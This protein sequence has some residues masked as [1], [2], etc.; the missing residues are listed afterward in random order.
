MLISDHAE[1]IGHSD[2]A[3]GL[4]IQN[5]AFARL[6]SY[7]SCD[8]GR[9]ESDLTAPHGCHWHE[10]NWC[11]TKGGSDIKFTPKE[12]RRGLGSNDH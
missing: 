7:I 11:S 10:Q 6:Q 3:A 12:N 1:D 5:F 2:N 9:V 8:C 4:L